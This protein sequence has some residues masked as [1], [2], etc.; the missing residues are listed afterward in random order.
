DFPEVEST[1]GIVVHELDGS[2][3]S[4]PNR[5]PH[6]FGRREQTRTDLLCDTRRRRLF[7]DLL[8][9][10]LH[11]AIALAE[12]NDGARAIAEDLHF[13]VSRALDVLLDEKPSFA[14]A[15]LRKPLDG[16]EAR[17]QLLHAPAKLHAD[18]AAACRA[19]QH[20]GKTDRVG[21]RHRILE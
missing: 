13:D 3:G 17:A 5:E 4:I 21:G 20:D 16:G 12:G 10:P 14:E 8:I 15:A 18:A 1:R 9:A 19:L 6:A 11:R 2:R 7:D